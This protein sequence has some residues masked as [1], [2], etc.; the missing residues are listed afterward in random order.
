MLPVLSPSTGHEASALNTMRNVKRS[1]TPGHPG[2]TS[3][4]SLPQLPAVQKTNVVKQAGLVRN[5]LSAVGNSWRFAVDPQGETNKYVSGA[6]DHLKNTGQLNSVV[7]DVSSQAGRS[8]VDAGLARL[9]DKVKGGITSAMGY[10]AEGADQLHPAVGSFIRNHPYLT[11]GGLAAGTGAL[12]WN[13]PRI[14]AALSRLTSGNNEETP[15]KLQLDGSA[16]F[17]ERLKQ[18]RERL[19][20]QR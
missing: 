17:R 16:A 2:A 6:L 8:A 4:L 3:L 20:T 18:V 12:L 14:T 13:A 5:A 1:L 9:T 7:N 15:R 19:R 10:V 11:A